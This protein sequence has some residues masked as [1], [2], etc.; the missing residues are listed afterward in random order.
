MKEKKET[1]SMLPDEELTR[2]SGGQEEVEWVC[3]Q[4][5]KH[6][7][8]YNGSGTFPSQWNCPYCGFLNE[9]AG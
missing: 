6:Y 9:P 3:P 4:C 1:N 7:T 2:V 8:I 5:G